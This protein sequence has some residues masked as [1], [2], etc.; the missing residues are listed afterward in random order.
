MVEGDLMNEATTS[1]PKD[2][3][4]R[5]GWF[6]DNWYLMPHTLFKRDYDY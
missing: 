4:A 6:H 2:V 1:T 3:D 5:W